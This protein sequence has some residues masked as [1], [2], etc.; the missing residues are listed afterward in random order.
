MNEQA[1]NI[2]IKLIKPFEGFRSEAYLCPAGVWTIGYGTTFYPRTGRKVKPGDICSEAN[3]EVYLKDCIRLY[4]LPEVEGFE[5]APPNV[6]GACISLIYNIGATAW[7][8][9]TARRKLRAGD[10]VGLAKA[11][12]LWNKAGGK[13]LPGLVRRRAAEADVILQGG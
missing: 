4:F 2:A 13:V 5:H 6:L 9:S 3:A 12:K 7:A 8:R 11:V 1:V 10:Y